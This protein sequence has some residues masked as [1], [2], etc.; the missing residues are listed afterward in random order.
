M[1]YPF[2]FCKKV[3]TIS[4]RSTSGAAMHIWYYKETKREAHT[5]TSGMSLAESII[6]IYLG[7]TAEVYYREAG[8]Y[9]V[10]ILK[11]ADADRT[12]L[13]QTADILKPNS[14]TGIMA[15]GLRRV[16]RQKQG[17]YG[18]LP[19]GYG[20][21]IEFITELYFILTCGKM[22]ALTLEAKGNGNGCRF[23]R[24]GGRRRKE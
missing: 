2:A 8:A 14:H 19:A 18:G 13:M 11:I 4:C 21:V 3:Y 10:L 15:V 7:R 12:Q 22:L 1:H 24:E 5:R 23:G 20:Y 6:A 16:Y 9:S 17:P